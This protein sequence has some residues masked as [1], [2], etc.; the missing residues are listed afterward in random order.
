M[1]LPSSIG[2][3]LDGIEETAADAAAILRLEAVD[4]DSLNHQRHR[5]RGLPHSTDQHAGNLA[6]NHI[7][8]NAIRHLGS[9]ILVSTGKKSEQVV[10]NFIKVPAVNPGIVEASGSYLGELASANPARGRVGIYRRDVLLPEP[11]GRLLAV[12]AE[13]SSKI[14]EPLV[15]AVPVIRLYRKRITRVWCSLVVSLNLARLS[16]IACRQFRAG[17]SLTTST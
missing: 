7:L 12:A 13:C 2:R 6:G 16:H 14:V 4:P 11:F 8:G 9:P 3:G 17:V 15:V 10:V 1:V 5:V